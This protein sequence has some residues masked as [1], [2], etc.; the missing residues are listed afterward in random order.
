MGCHVTLDSKKS[1]SMSLA[2]KFDDIIGLH[3]VSFM[4]KLGE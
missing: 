3:F 4:R 1:K 2:P